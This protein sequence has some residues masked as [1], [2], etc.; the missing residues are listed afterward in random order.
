[1]PRY[2]SGHAVV[3]TGAGGGIG[4]SIALHLARCGYHVLAAVHREESLAGLAAAASTE[5]LTLDAV[6]ADTSERDAVRG[7]FGRAAGFPEALHGVVLCAGVT[8]RLSLLDTTDEDFAG[9]IQVNL[10][11]TFFGLREAGLAFRENDS[12]GSIVAVTS[13]NAFRA[14]PSQAAYSATKAGIQSL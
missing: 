1:M 10:T 8:K 14:L 11:G 4:S 13:I 2:G 6:A 9:L 7:L 3:V 12:G 5:D